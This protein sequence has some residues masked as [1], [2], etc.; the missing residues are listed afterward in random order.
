MSFNPFKKIKKFNP[1]KIVKKPVNK[2]KQIF[3]KAK[4]EVEDIPEE[5]GDK[6]RD[7]LQ[8]AVDEARELIAKEGENILRVLT[9]DES[10]MKLGKVMIYDMEHDYDK[11]K[12]IISMLTEITNKHGVINF[13]RFVKPEKVGLNLEAEVPVVTLGVGWY[14]RWKTEKFLDFAERL[15]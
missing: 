8:S 7:A 4:D 3:T 1:I 11:N 12:R 15:I 5:L 2:V 13:I 14:P 6:I 9:P 10:D